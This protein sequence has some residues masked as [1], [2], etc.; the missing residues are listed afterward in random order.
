MHIVLKSKNS[1][2]LKLV[3][4]NCDKAFVCWMNASCKKVTL[5]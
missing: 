1:F 5:D 2:T 4:I 3:D